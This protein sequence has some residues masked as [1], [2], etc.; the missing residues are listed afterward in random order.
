M[1]KELIDE[2][3]LKPF[4]GNDLRK[5]IADR[6]K[7]LRGKFRLVPLQINRYNQRLA[8][9]L[10]EKWKE[11]NRLYRKENKR[12]KPPERLARWKEM[13][14]RYRLYGILQVSD[15]WYNILRKLR[16]EMA[17]I[18]ALYQFSEIDRLPDEQVDWKETTLDEFDS[19]V[20]RMK[21]PHKPTRKN[22]RMKDLD[23]SVKDA[24]LEMMQPLIE[25]ADETKKQIDSLTAPRKQMKYKTKV[26][27]FRNAVKAREYLTVLCQSLA[28]RSKGLK[29]MR[30]L[31]ELDDDEEV[32]R[33][34]L[35][36]D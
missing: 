29:M 19:L 7:F 8:D 21:G 9:E 12:E 2:Q 25:W 18:V 28:P 35:D 11:E 14:R 15:K 22:Y 33:Q 3:S 23:Y 16:G 5:S 4:K 1:S 27:R 34:V 32:W 26:K 31:D 20:L 36:T 6:I 30:E 17:L 13:S 10:E 24:F